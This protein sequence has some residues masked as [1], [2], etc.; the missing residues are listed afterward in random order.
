MPFN[1]NEFLTKVGYDNLKKSRFDVTIKRNDF[2]KMAL[3]C[4]SC[5]LPGFQ[6]LTKDYKMYSGMPNL[7]VPNGREHDDIDLTFISSGDMKERKLFDEWIY[8]ISNF[9]TNNV[10]YFKDIVSDI[11][12]SVYNEMPNAERVESSIQ[13]AGFETGQTGATTTKTSGQKLAPIYTVDLINA[14]PLRV[15]TLPVSWEDTDQIQKF[16]VTVTYEQ[17]KFKTNSTSFGYQQEGVTYADT[18]P[19]AKIS[20]QEMNNQIPVQFTPRAPMKF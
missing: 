19:V 17:L 14:Y 9:S 4:E 2:Y 5:S 12:I 3:R 8:L 15:E 1:L 11:Q 10:S 6:I 18:P 13:Y 7:K 16:T 20:A